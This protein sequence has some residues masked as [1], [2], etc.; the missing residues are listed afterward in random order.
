[1][2]GKSD[3]KYTGHSNVNDPITGY[4][5]Q[6][7]VSMLKRCKPG[8]REAHL[9][10]ERGV[11]VCERWNVFDN[12]LADMGFR[13]EGKTLDRWPDMDGGYAPSNCRWA[14]P[15]EQSR[16]RVTAKLTLE[17]A[18]EIA[19]LRLDGESGPSIA[20]KYGVSP[21][22]VSAIGTGRD[23][24][25]AIEAAKKVIDARNSE[26]QQG[27]AQHTTKD[28]IEVKRGQLWSSFDKR[29]PGR[30][31]RVGRVEGGRAQMVLIVNGQPGRSTWIP[32]RRMYKYSAGWVLAAH[33]AS[34]QG[35]GAT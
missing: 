20:S 1:M 6:S 13:P 4:T 16:N 3:Y 35:G 23:W 18:I 21:R 22:L 29:N 32:I 19:V 30:T 34:A 8:Y 5:Y 9:Y 10:F 12:F 14:T 2:T 11:T 15:R 24:P 28:G 25:D 33:Q 17:S 27:S 31:C 26:T 7:W